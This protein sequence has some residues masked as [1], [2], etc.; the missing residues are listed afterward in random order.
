MSAT[1][2]RFLAKDNAGEIQSSWTAS[3][4]APG[5]SKK[6]KAWSFFWN[7]IT[8]GTRGR[9]TYKHYA[10]IWCEYGDELSKSHNS[11]YEGAGHQKEKGRH[12]N[13][14][15]VCTKGNQSAAYWEKWH[16]AIIELRDLN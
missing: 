3:I 10:E 4:W 7:I 14:V 1:T 2:I 6:A 12:D 13:G 5:K 8:F 9:S 15:Q 16:H 11:A